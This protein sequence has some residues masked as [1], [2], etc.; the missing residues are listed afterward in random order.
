MSNKKNLKVVD[1]KKSI[2]DERTP[3]EYFDEAKL[4][5]ITIAK[6]CRKNAT[7][8]DKI[9]Q[10]FAS[11]NKDIKTTWDRA[12]DYCVIQE[13]TYDSIIERLEDLTFESMS[14]FDDDPFIDLID[15][16]DDNRYLLIDAMDSYAVFEAVRP[17][18]EKIEA[19][20]MTLKEM[21]DK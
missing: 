5:L 16:I 12:I 3:E 18:G 11:L 8:V 13:N 6:S 9:I 2:A 20:K 10:T 4:G 14:N 21:Q 1:N 7:R 17:F 15:Y 19:L